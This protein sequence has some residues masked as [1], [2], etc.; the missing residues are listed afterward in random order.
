MEAFIG[1]LREVRSLT[2]AETEWLGRMYRFVELNLLR[3]VED[4][5]VSVATLSGRLVRCLSE[6]CTQADERRLPGTQAEPLPLPLAYTLVSISDLCTKSRQA[7]SSSLGPRFEHLL[8]WPHGGGGE[9]ARLEVGEEGGRLVGAEDNAAQADVEPHDGLLPRC[10]LLLCGRVTDRS[11]EPGTQPDGS[12]F[13]RDC[14][15]ALQCE[16][17]DFPAEWLGE[18]VLLPCWSYVPGGEPREPPHGYVEVHGGPLRL[19]PGGDLPRRRRPR[20]AIAA[21]RPDMARC[22]LLACGAKR[23]RRAKFSLLGE[24]LSVAPLLCI[25][26]KSFFVLR[27]GSAFSTSSQSLASSSLQSVLCF[28]QTPSKLFWS[29]CLRPHEHYLITD[30]T[31]TTV[32]GTRPVFVVSPTSELHPAGKAHTRELGLKEAL[33]ASGVSGRDFQASCRAAAAARPDGLARETERS[34]SPSNV[35]SYRGV[36]TRVI[37]AHG[38]LYELDGEVG[39]CLAYQQGL[40]LGRGLR[41]GATLEVH[42]AHLVRCPCPGSPR[43]VLVACA[44]GSVRAASFSPL[45]SPWAPLRAPW[46]A[47][48]RALHAAGLSPAAYFRLLH[49]VRRLSE[50]LCPDLIAE[51]CLTRWRADPADRGV[52]HALFLSPG[53]RAEAPRGGSPPGSASESWRRGWTGCLFRKGP[54]RDVYLE[55]LEEP[56]RCVVTRPDDA[57]DGLWQLPSMSEVLKMAEEE[58][59]KVSEGRCPVDSEPPLAREDSSTAARPGHSAESR[60]AWE[61]SVFG[62]KHF[63]PPVILVGVLRASARTGLLQLADRTAA[64]DCLAVRPRPLG[65][66]RTACRDAALLGCLVRLSCFSLVVERFTDART[67]GTRQHLTRIYAQFHADE[68]TALYRPSGGVRL[69]AA[70]GSSRP[71]QARAGP[72][73]ERPPETQEDVGRGDEDLSSGRASPTARAASQQ[74]AAGPGPASDGAANGT[75]EGRGEEG[76]L[77]AR[78]QRRG[79]GEIVAPGA[80][81]ARGA[82]RDA[83]EL[84]GPAAKTWRR[85]DDNG[86]HNGGHNGDHNGGRAQAARA[87]APSRNDGPAAAAAAAAALPS[88][89]RAAPPSVSV[90]KPR[91]SSGPGGDGAAGVRRETRP[92]GPA[93]RSEAGDRRGGPPSGGPG[94]RGSVARVFV[95]THKEA[96][97]VRGEGSAPG[98]S[99]YATVRILEETVPD[100]Q[101]ATSDGPR[102]GSGGGS[103]GEPGVGKTTQM[104]FVGEA[105]RWH[106][107]LHPGGAYELL[108]PS[109]QEASLYSPQ[110]G[111]PAGVLQAAGCPHLIQLMPNWKIRSLGRPESPSRTQLEPQPSTSSQ[112]SEESDDHRLGLMNIRDVLEES[113]EQLVSF[114]GQ[115]SER[116]CY[117]PHDRYRKLHDSASRKRLG[118]WLPGDPDLRFDVQ[119]LDSPEL[120]VSVYLDPSCF[121]YPLGLLP[122]ATVAFRRLQRC[123]SRVRKNVYCKI[124]PVSSMDVTSFADASASPLSDPWG[125][126]APTVQIADLLLRGQQRVT[127]GR[128]GCRVVRIRWLRLCWACA[129]CGS[130]FAQGQCSGASRGTCNSEEGSFTAKASVIVDDGTGHAFM[131]M[132]GLQVASLLALSLPQWEALHRHILNT[133]GEASFSYSDKFS[134]VTLEGLTENLIRALCCSRSVSRPLCLRFRIK[135]WAQEE[136]QEQLRPFEFELKKAAYSTLVPCR[137]TLL[138]MGVRD[139]AAHARGAGCQES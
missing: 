29:S 35:I 75:V 80:P 5:G 67:T 114:T 102:G 88:G 92:G 27:L 126:G 3:V 128:L 129:I 134:R 105:V 127:S 15:G 68:A 78:Q 25:R 104:Y 17:S 106:S 99:F 122:G 11:S 121:V 113:C 38:G 112:R 118:I 2:N 120:S 91:G 59:R 44:L 139:P 30:V 94:G 83:A 109:E 43:A 64:L 61:F 23:S 54:K 110:P 22:L 69:T 42:Q 117:H 79:S 58:S 34:G 74:R 66:G 119:D 77:G 135:T 52:V 13:L 65:R 95:V 70:A 76:A 14:T 55:I 97:M 100:E 18:L 10:P 4:P 16:L 8:S 36:L 37:N 56:H 130:N 131:Y 46:S 108:L 103:G 86:G 19:V 32:N 62:P 84:V 82:K 26:G 24:L 132:D 89:E 51:R 125:D 33:T 72:A 28:V 138:C 123:T 47:P 81:G 48:V 90:T 98:L 115:I 101:R 96:L 107:I 9:G 87:A 49:E 111:V 31:M 85:N 133:S 137:P 136:Q 21:L 20:A 41:I 12:L 57:D 39:L 73:A 93:G 116:F 71:E 124:L 6:H 60:K 45:A 1:E 7:F 63:E 53:E 40:H 50:R